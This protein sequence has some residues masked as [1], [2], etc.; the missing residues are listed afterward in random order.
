[1]HPNKAKR[2]TYVL[3][4]ETTKVL[5][6]F[7]TPLVKNHKDQLSKST[8]IKLVN[9][10]FSEHPHKR[11]AGALTGNTGLGFKIQK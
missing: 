3:V 11:E 2:S 7:S 4:E 10:N 1:V 8:K 9:T 6:S 5:E